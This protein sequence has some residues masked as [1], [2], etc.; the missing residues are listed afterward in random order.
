MVFN[1]GEHL[2]SIINKIQTFQSTFLRHID[3]AQFY[4]SNDIFY[5]LSYSYSPKYS[6]NILQRL[7]SNLF[8]YHRNLFT[9]NLST[10]IIFGDPRKRLKRIKW[11][12]LLENKTH[13]TSCYEVS[14][15]DGFFSH[16]Y[17]LD[18]IYEIKFYRIYFIS[19][20][21]EKLL[22]TDWKLKKQKNKTLTIFV[23]WLSD[24]TY[25][26]EI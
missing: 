25:V 3:K 2:N 6:Q 13:N 14:S 1:L 20:N 15:I 21:F 26:V 17:C 18:I 11:S 5:N 4:V 8:K 23:L 10:H 24:I 19:Y 9:F 22:F 16:N 12:E 7:H